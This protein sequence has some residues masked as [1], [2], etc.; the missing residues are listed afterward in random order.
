MLACEVLSATAAVRNLIREGKAYQINNIIQTGSSRG[1]QSMERNLAD[2]SRK[3]YV[4]PVE[5]RLRSPN[6]QLFDQYF[7]KE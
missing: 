5:A 7:T 1:M 3:G 6:P 2:L 4:D